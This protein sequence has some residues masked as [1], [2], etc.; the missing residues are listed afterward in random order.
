MCQYRLP[1]LPSSVDLNKG[2]VAKVG[3]LTPD[4]LKM[5]DDVDEAPSERKRAET[6]ERVTQDIG[7]MEGVVVFTSAVLV[8]GFSFRRFRY[9]NRLTW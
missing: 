8:A 9:S 2:R 7:G 6:E 4:F 5:P 1:L 3:I